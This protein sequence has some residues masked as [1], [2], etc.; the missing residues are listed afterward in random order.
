MKLK[1]TEIKKV[2]KI[3]KYG[4]QQW[5]E[6]NFS[7]RNKKKIKEERR[8]KSGE[9][10]EKEI[11]S[12]SESRNTFLSLQPMNEEEI[13]KIYIKYAEILKENEKLKERLNS[14]EAKHKE[15]LQ[16]YDNQLNKDEDKKKSW[17]K[18]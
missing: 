15:T 14:K 11:D 6:R 7:K 2:K 16:I 12:K 10:A 13:K 5:K 8:S 3:K 17:K 1:L 9:R 18:F 4:F